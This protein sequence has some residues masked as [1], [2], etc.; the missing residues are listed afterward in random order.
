MR[1]NFQ[2]KGDVYFRIQLRK[3]NI[4]FNFFLKKIKNVQCFVISDCLNCG[5]FERGFLNRR[6]FSGKL[7]ILRKMQNLIGVKGMY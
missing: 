1:V 7:K 4:F 5:S 3:V 6:E 2:G